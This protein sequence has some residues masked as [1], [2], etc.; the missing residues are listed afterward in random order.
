MNESPSSLE[1]IKVQTVDEYKKNFVFAEVAKNDFSSEV[2]EELEIAQNNLN[3]NLENVDLYNTFVDTAEK[4]KKKLKEKYGD[5]WT[6]P[7]K[8][9]AEKI[10]A[11]D[12]EWG[13]R[14]SSQ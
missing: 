7:A 5:Q 14:H 1:K 2:L 8:G 11:N 12:D 13:S 9:I 6:D 10:N 4:A 3:A